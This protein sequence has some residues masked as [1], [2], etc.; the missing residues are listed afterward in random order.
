MP[1]ES[2]TTQSSSSSDNNIKS[3][4]NKVT[5]YREKIEVANAHDFTNFINQ[6]YPQLKQVLLQRIPPQVYIYIHICYI[7]MMN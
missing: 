6:V 3:L 1:G 2:N 7:E 5:G 4:L